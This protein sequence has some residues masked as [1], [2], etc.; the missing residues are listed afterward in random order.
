[1]FL[2]PSRHGAGDMAP[3]VR[4]GGV[5]AVPAAGRRVL[6]RGRRAALARTIA[7]HDAVDGMSLIPSS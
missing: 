1:M 7:Y 4:A 2:V 3:P 5:G 6:H